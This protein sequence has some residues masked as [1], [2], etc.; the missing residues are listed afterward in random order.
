MVSAS[1][2]WKPPWLRALCLRGGAMTSADLTIVNPKA[3][4]RAAKLL[5][6]LLLMLL[7]LLLLL[8]LLAAGCWLL[9]AAVAAGCCCC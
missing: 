1:P 4:L 3:Q 2:A 9:A 8:L 6:L 7:L 5:M